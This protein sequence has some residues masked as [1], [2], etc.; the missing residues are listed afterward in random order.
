M[1][2]RLL[3]PQQWSRLSSRRNHHTNSKLKLERSIFGALLSI[4][5]LQYVMWAVVYY[6]LERELV[7]CVRVCARLRRVNTGPLQSSHSVFRY[8]CR[9]ACG[10]SKKQPWCVAHDVVRWPAALR[11]ATDGD[12]VGLPRLSLSL[13]AFF[14]VHRNCEHLCIFNVL[15]LITTLYRCHRC[16]SSHKGTGLKPVAFVAETST[17]W[18]CGELAS[19]FFKALFI[20]LCEQCLC[21]CAVRRLQGYWD[22]AVL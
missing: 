22:E 1:H 14:I 13:F 21:D 8:I 12:T 16:D 6:R 10:L 5:H 3:K 4:F 18:M 20:L 9:C 7:W 11:L 19:A 2:S 15:R 17:V